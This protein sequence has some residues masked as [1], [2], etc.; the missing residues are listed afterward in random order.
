MET[1]AEISQSD[2]GQ[3]WA[4]SQKNDPEYKIIRL[5]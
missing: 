2:E 5:L 3:E 4:S 1:K